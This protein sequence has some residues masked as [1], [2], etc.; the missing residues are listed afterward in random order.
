MSLTISADASVE[1]SLSEA[2]SAEASLSEVLSA[3]ASLSEAPFAEASLSES[4]GE[5][6]Y[7]M[8][9]MLVSSMDH[10]MSSKTVSS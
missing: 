10:V 9:A 1:A 5:F 8:E 4:V 3:E 6:V 7:S 2:L